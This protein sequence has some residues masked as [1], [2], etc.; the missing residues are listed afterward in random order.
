M[1]EKN[2]ASIRIGRNAHRADITGG[3]IQTS[4]SL[5]SLENNASITIEGDADFA[6]ITGGQISVDPGMAELK[7]EIDQILNEL[8]KNPRTAKTVVALEI[9]KEE[10]QENP[11]FRQR[12]LSAVK[13]G[14]VEALK[15]VF[16]HP[17]VSIPVE[18][19]RGFLEPS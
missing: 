8:A 19:V 11:T 14:G 2:D 12:L 18:A 3:T 10:I 6:T 1:I 9:I 17:V 7:A 13:A 4:K 5:D 16:N 15:A